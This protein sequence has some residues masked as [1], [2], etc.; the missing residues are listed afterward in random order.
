M[1][2]TLTPPEPGTSSSPSATDDNAGGNALPARAY[3]APPTNDY[4]RLLTVPST[5]TSEVNSSEEESDKSQR[6]IIHRRILGQTGHIQP[7]RTTAFS[8]QEPVLQFSSEQ[9]LVTVDW[10]IPLSSYQT[11]RLLHGFCPEVMEDKWFVYA[12]G[13]DTSGQAFVHFNRSWTG[14]KMA[15]LSVKVAGDTDDEGEAWSGCIE[16]LT[17]EKE[18]EG[19]KADEGCSEGMAKFIVLE[20]CR[21][22]LQIC[23]CE[24]LADPPEWRGLSE[25]RARYVPVMQTSYRGASADDETIAD[26]Q[27]LIALGRHPEV[28]LD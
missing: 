16:R 1:S 25:R 9:D 13:P 26:A 5:E 24:N 20:V 4:G 8:W 19:E 6:W 3:Y 12:E 14:K 2:S 28:T 10:G 21:L 17:W 18:G 22:V 7:E 11:G 23:L 15:V 27:R